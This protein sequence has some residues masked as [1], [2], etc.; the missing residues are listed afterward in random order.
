[1]AVEPDNIYKAWLN[2]SAHDFYKG[3]LSARIRGNRHPHITQNIIDA[4]H[5]IYQHTPAGMAAAV[6]PAPNFQDIVD[7]FTDHINNP[8]ESGE[9][10]RGGAVGNRIRVPASGN[11]ATARIVLQNYIFY[12]FTG[13]AR[14][15][16]ANGTSI[17]NTQVAPIPAHAIYTVEFDLATNAAPANPIHIVA[18]AG[19][20]I[21]STLYKKCYT[22]AERNGNNCAL[23]LIMVMTI[24]TICDSA[25]TLTSTVFGRPIMILSNGPDASLNP[26]ILSCHV[27]S[28]GLN[29]PITYLNNTIQNGIG[30]VLPNVSPYSYI[31]IGV[32]PVYYSN[33]G[34]SAGSLAIRV[35]AIPPAANISP[36]LLSNVAIQNLSK[37]NYLDIKRCGDSL[38]I[39]YFNMIAPQLVNCLF[40]TGDRL[41]AILAGYF[42]RQRAIFQS[43]VY[44]TCF[45][46]DGTANQLV[47]GDR[48]YVGGAIYSV[49][50]EIQE[51]TRDELLECL[52]F[53]GNKWCQE[54]RSI[55]SHNFHNNVYVPST[56]LYC[57]KYYTY[58]Y[59]ILTPQLCDTTINVRTINLN[60]TPID[61]I[62]QLY[63]QIRIR[64]IIQT[65]CSLI[66][67]IMDYSDVILNN[68]YIRVFP[69]FIY[70][71]VHALHNA[72]SDIDISRFHDILSRYIL[73]FIIIHDI[74]SDIHPCTSTISYMIFGSVH[75]TIKLNNNTIGKYLI[76]TN[77]DLILLYDHITRIFNAL[78][79]VS[80]PEL[81]SQ[82]HT[83]IL[84]L[85]E[86]TH[87]SPLESSKAMYLKKTRKNPRKHPYR[88][89][90]NRRMH[91]TTNN[92]LP[93]LIPLLS[94]NLFGGK[95][96]YKSHK[97][98]INKKCINKTCKYKIDRKHTHKRKTRK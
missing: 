57:A 5:D 43:S 15:L 92:D 33:T 27:D 45:I 89:N 66:D 97:K 21:L 52:E 81:A 19:P 50:N 3:G 25:T 29:G 35:K 36:F 48:S 83:Y 95:H 9:M 54:F 73:C 39:S 58:G 42:Y 6:I 4:A 94:Q 93:P 28:G 71:I 75:Y 17:L 77:E 85:I 38:Q 11:R 68:V 76:G 41:C 10:L 40:F 64:C 62:I 26:A 34:P 18:D 47:G 53:I 67:I 82:L 37:N 22:V 16:H 55:I 7:H 13:D 69:N 61:R 59:T 84:S 56:Q 90:H 12:S 72:E 96:K 87:I 86:I 44:K 30:Y 88:H 23:N 80:I 32:T 70:D 65:K 20:G 1:M 51:N 46:V 60:N 14:Y 49:G 98:R 8:E 91:S 2:D 78:L 63:E 74:L 24:A 79:D 31:N